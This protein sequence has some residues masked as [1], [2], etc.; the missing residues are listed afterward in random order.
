MKREKPVLDIAGNQYQIDLKNKKFIPLEPGVKPMVLGDFECEMANRDYFGYYDL[1]KKEPVQFGDDL[2]EFPG[3]HIVAVYFPADQYLDPIA[4]AEIHEQDYDAETDP[5]FI[6]IH[7][8]YC[9]PMEESS[10]ADMV[11]VNQEMAA[12]KELTALENKQEKIEGEKSQKKVGK[13]RRI[14]PGK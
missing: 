2:T 6:D 8:A 11:Q 13:G 3:P 4:Y 7:E 1:E 10:L 5:P 12:K 9:G 14:P